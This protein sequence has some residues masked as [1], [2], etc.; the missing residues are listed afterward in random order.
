MYTWS[1]LLIDATTSN[2][3]GKS[4]YITLSNGNMTA[5][6]S[7][8]NN[9]GAVSGQPL[10]KTQASGTGK[11]P[12]LTYQTTAS[13]GIGN[14]SANLNE[15]VGYDANGMSYQNNG[16]KYYDG[17]NA[18]YGT[19]YT[20]GDVIGVALDL[21]DGTITFYKDGATQNTAYI[22]VSALGTP[23]YPMVSIYSPAPASTTSLTMAFAPNS[24]QY[25]P[26]SGYL[27]WDSSLPNATTNIA[28]SQTIPAAGGSGSGYTFTVPSGSLPAGLTLSSGRRP[29]RHSYYY[30]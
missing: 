20:T 10:P 14:A 2:R 22:N 8:T 23:V 18:A 25:S 30:R 13:L 15:Y 7:I 19:S 9:Y 27:P 26:P 29:V 4:G 11:L 21:T 12:A 28:Y 3:N 24:F 16:T 5:T 6:D 17:T 1:L